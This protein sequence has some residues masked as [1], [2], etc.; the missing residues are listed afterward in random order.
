MVDDSLEEQNVWLR[1]MHL[2]VLPAE[3]LF[4]CQIE[5]FVV[6]RTQ[7]A[8]LSNAKSSPFF[9]PQQL[10]C[11]SRAVKVLLGYHLEHLLGELYMSVLVVVVRVSSKW[12]ISLMVADVCA[13][14]TT[15]LEE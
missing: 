6:A 11:A 9:L 2:V 7:I 13:S 15:Y 5:L 4:S 3:A 12:L 8:Y 1:L 14:F 10:E